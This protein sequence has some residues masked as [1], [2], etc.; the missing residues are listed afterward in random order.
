M[1]LDL[2][3]IPMDITFKNDGEKTKM[4]LNRL[5]YKYVD[6]GETITITAN[7]SEEAAIISTRLK[8]LGISTNDDGGDDE[9]VDTLPDKLYRGNNIS[10]TFKD[11]IDPKIFADFETKVFE[12]VQLEIEFMNFIA[13]H[14][15]KGDLD[16]PEVQAEYERLN[17]EGIAKAQ[18]LQ[19]KYG[20]YID[21]NDQHKH[22]GLFETNSDVFAP[23]SVTIRDGE[24]IVYFYPSFANAMQSMAEIVSGGIPVD[25]STVTKP[26]WYLMDIG[27]E[28]YTCSPCDAPKDFSMTDI[29]L[30]DITGELPYIEKSVYSKF[31]KSVEIDGEAKYYTLK[32]TGLDEYTQQYTLVFNDN[33]TLTVGLGQGD[34]EYTRFIPVT[35]T[36]DVTITI[37]LDNGEVAETYNRTLSLDEFTDY[38]YELD[39]AGHM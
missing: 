37:V 16:D 22:V 14:E 29:I 17:A 35:Y 15:A 32:V 38:Q 23:I 8:E 12:L 24:K 28:L 27:D 13:E 39:V 11:Y 5:I 6:N 9:D 33:S 19:S 3:K 21:S 36:G 2:S 34:T 4:L 1:Q 30:S 18:A 31:F 10:I 26:G 25:F 20:Q 7:S